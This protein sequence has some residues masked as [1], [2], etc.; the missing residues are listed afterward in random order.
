MKTN[1][2]SRTY[3]IT[4]EQ[5]KKVKKAAREVSESATIRRLIDTL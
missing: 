5:D 4:R 1:L 2:I 3:R